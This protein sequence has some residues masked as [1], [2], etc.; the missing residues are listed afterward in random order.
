MTIED[1]GRVLL[2]NGNE[3]LFEGRTDALKDNLGYTLKVSADEHGITA[4]L[5]GKIIVDYKDIVKARDSV[6]FCM[7]KEWRAVI[8]KLK[9]VAD[10]KEYEDAINCENYNICESGYFISDGAKRDRLPWTGDLDWAF[11]SGFT[12]SEADAKRSI[13]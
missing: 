13:R 5:D 2:K 10:G 11:G 3:T 7:K 6:G 8:D 1:S 4:R 9:V 12:A